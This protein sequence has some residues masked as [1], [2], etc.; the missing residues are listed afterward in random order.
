MTSSSKI[1][2]FCPN[3]LASG[4]AWKVSAHGKKEQKPEKKGG[5][6]TEGEERKRRT[7]RG[8][9]ERGGGKARSLW[10]AQLVWEVAARKQVDVTFRC[11]P[12]MQLFSSIV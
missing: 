1:A 10:S 11:I 9:R 12:L 8:E 6:K 5:K 3:V 2:A 7:G 4:Q